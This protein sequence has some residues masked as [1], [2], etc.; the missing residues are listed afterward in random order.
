MRNPEVGQP[1]VEDD[2]GWCQEKLFGELVIEARL[3]LGV[4]VDENHVQIQL[5][6][7]NPQS[8][9]LLGMRSWP[10]VPVAYMPER[11]LR[12]LQS[13]LEDVEALM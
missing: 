13:M 8:G 4:Q 10:H 12:A 5:E 11:A 7:R 2:T 3:T 9:I 1:C 6:V